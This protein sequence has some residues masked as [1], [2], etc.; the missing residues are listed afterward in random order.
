[1]TTRVYVGLG[2]NLGDRRAHL[3]AA[4]KALKPALVSSYL[5]T[6][7]LVLPGAEAQP[8][9]LNA[10]AAIDTLLEPRDFLATLRAIERAQGR[11]AERARWQPRTLDLDI[12]LFGERIIDEAE[13]RVPHAHLH[14]R[15]FVLLPLAEIAPEARH[16]VLRKAVSELLSL[17]RTD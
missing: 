7:A 1:M 12:L 14:E 17:L 6:P 16:P 4:V 9:Y 2:S 8:A 3:D 5:E 15:R 11:P 13:L 10:A